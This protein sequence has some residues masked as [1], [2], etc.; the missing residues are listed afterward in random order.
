MK[1]TVFATAFSVAM[2]AVLLAQAGGTMSKGDGMDKMAKPGKMAKMEKMDTRTTYTGCLEAGG[3]PGTFVLTHA[4]RMDGSMHA[5]S[6]EKEAMADEA[7][8]HDMMQPASLRVASTSV[9]LT[10]HLG[11]KVS[12]TGMTSNRK[13]SM[14]AE[15]STFTIKT[16]KMVASSCS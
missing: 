1:R 3:A 15:E 10:K 2:S 9:G 8:A 14:G 13:D 16:L 11:H 4:D 6:M 12:V 5:G 7:M